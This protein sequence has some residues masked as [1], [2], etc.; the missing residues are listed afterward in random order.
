MG[1]VRRWGPERAPA[2]QSRAIHAS[3]LLRSRAS[4][5]CA[6]AAVGALWRRPAGGVEGDGGWEEDAMARHVKVA[7]AQMGPNNEGV[8]REEIVVPARKRWNFFGRRRPEHYGAITAPT[9][10]AP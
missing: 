5:P 1:S 9:A 6:A 4:D 2:A 7:A 8:S 10:P 3:V